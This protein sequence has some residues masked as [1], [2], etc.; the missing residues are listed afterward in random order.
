MASLC[1]PSSL[2]WRISELLAGTADG[3]QVTRGY[4]V[5]LYRASRTALQAAA[6]TQIHGAKWRK[7]FRG[8]GN[9]LPQGMAV[10]QPDAL[11]ANDDFLY[12]A[13]LRGAAHVGFGTQSADSEVGKTQQ[14]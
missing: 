4:V 11:A 5:A 12:G 7:S 6:S 13:F 8:L 3:G 9:A 1:P 2:I 10:Q 14:G